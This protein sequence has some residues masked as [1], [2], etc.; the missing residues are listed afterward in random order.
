L[1][2]IQDETD[3]SIKALDAVIAAKEEEIMEF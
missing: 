3:A 2:R 1:K